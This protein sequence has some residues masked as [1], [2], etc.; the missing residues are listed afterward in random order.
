MSPHSQMNDPARKRTG[1]HLNK[2]YYLNAVA[3]YGV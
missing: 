2:D 3:S 1:Y